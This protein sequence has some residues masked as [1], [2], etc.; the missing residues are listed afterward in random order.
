MREP[1][2]Q[3]LRRRR[4]L[5]DGAMGTRLLEAGLE[6][7]KCGDEW[8]LTHPD[9]VKAVHAG[10]VAAS[11]DLV[12][13]N[14]FQAS[15]LA[16]ARHGLSG[17]AYDINVAAARLARD[18]IGASG[19]VI[20]DVGPFGGFL[21]PLGSTSRRQLEEGFAI[22]AQGLVD[23]GVDAIIIETMTALEEV[24]IAVD[25]VRKF[26]PRLP[27]IASITFDRVADGGFRTMTGVTVDD[28]VRFMHD[29]GVDVLGCNC[30]TGLHIG[31]Y[32]QLVSLY[33]KR[34]DRPIMVQ[35]NAGQPRLEPGGRIVYDET[36]EGMAAAVPRLLAE[37]ATIIGG[38][39]GTTAEHIRLF[40]Q[41]M[42]GAT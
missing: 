40:R 24:R 28:A 30:G 27:V 18:C 25:T 21:E 19:Y 10:Y 8:N 1:F 36:P 16:L 23:G 32:V 2:L 34:T 31:D 12:L 11:S 20:G 38:C 7:G 33:R 5:G 14:T 29:Q 9:R 15:G 37:G 22:Q 3:T 41:R 6:I 17:K 13:T 42:G 35:P 4:L 39:C 26:A